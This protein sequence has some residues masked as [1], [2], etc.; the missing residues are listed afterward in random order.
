MMPQRKIERLLKP[1][2][3]SEWLG[4]SLSTLYSWRWR[5]EGPPGF[6]VGR[7][8]RY[9]VEDVE[10]WLTETASEREGNVDDV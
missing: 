10:R 8:V 3:L 2:D 4:V 9:R 5:G 6:R 7:L 1:T